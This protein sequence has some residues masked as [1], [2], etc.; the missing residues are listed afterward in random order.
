[1]FDK[2]NIIFPNLPNFPTQKIIAG[3]ILHADKR[4]QAQTFY[5]SEE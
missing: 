4:R 5:Q 3:D 2:D 1:M